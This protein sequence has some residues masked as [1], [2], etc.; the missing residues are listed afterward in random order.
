MAEINTVDYLSDT[1]GRETTPFEQDPLFEKILTLI[2]DESCNLEDSLVDISKYSGLD[3][4]KGGALDLIGVLV[5]QGRSLPASTIDI[6]A[7]PYFGFNGASSAGTFGDLNN[8]ELGAVFL[9]QNQIDGG[10]I[11]L[12]DN[13]YRF[14]IRAKI[15]SNTTKATPEDVI[16]S[17]AF[18]FNPPTI[19]YAESNANIYL[20]L[21][22]KLNDT[23]GEFSSGIDESSIAS[24]YLGRPAGV[25]LIIYDYDSE[26]V[27]GFEG[28][29]GSLG[30]GDLLDHEIGGTFAELIDDRSPVIQELIGT[31]GDGSTMGGGTTMYSYYRT[32]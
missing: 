22:R 6:G 20:G 21:G 5:G 8:P 30:F 13:V 19:S 28:D 3:T 24:Q 2:L 4:A 14:F 12:S 17:A 15:T 18:L 7:L 26:D 16:Q 11:T 1:I 9:D 25:G 32:T 29:S 27:F 10:T 31:M 23:D